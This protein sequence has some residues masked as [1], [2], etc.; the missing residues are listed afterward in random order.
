M[1]RR[2][3]PMI[4]P[5]ACRRGCGA[6]IYTL[7]RAGIMGEEARRRWAGICADCWTPEDAAEI[8]AYARGHMVQMAGGLSM[9]GGG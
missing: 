7:A 5:V 4:H 1:R 6:T 3:G 2:K 9:K 8:D